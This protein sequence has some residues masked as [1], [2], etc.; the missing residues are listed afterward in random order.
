MSDKTTPISKKIIKRKYP[1]T[2][3]KHFGDM[4]RK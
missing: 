1:L 4:K 3:R 2:G